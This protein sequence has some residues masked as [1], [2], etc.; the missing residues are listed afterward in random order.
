MN[1]ILEEYFLD[2]E[3]QEMYDEFYTENRDEIKQIQKELDGD[4]YLQSEE[5]IEV[6]DT[7]F[8]SWSIKHSKKFE[9]K[10]TE[11]N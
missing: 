6:V 4:S 5:C 8:E 10:Q 11:L 9:T 2:E 7:M 3:L 1:N